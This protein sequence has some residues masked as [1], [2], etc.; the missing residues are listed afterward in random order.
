MLTRRVRYV[1]S[2]LGPQDWEN[3]AFE[4]ANLPPEMPNDIIKEYMTKYGIVNGVTD[5]NW[6][7]MY[8]YVVGNGIRIATVDFPLCI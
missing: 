5:E 3:G 1:R 4:I 2:P 6:S 7:N 8:R